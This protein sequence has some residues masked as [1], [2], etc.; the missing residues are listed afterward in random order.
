MC[1]LFLV[2]TGVC[3]FYWHSEK[4]SCSH[5]QSDLQPIYS[6]QQETGN[7]TESYLDAPSSRLE[8]LITLILSSSSPG[9]NE[10]TVTD[11]AF[12]SNLLQL[13]TN[14]VWAHLWGWAV[15]GRVKE[16]LHFCST[17]VPVGLYTSP[18]ARTGA[19]DTEPSFCSAEPG[20][21]VIHCF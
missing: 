7:R 8:D 4:P 15:L 16:S 3:F 21:E 11:S 18:A 13:Q 19:P 20:G 6:H 5:R 12:K 1:T 14:S 10:T 17:S 2:L 9:I